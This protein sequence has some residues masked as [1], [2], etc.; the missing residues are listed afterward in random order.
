M[1][2]ITCTARR[3]A[4]TF[5][6][7]LASLSGAIAPAPWSPTA[8]AADT[9]FVA[10]AED[11][12]SLRAEPAYGAEILATLA[13]G[14]QV[15]LRTD[16]ADTVND[17]DG[18]TR[19]WPVRTDAG[20]GWVAGFY[21]E[22]DGW[23][24]PAEASEPSA[25]EAA[26]AAWLD[27]TPAV[28]DGD[29]GWN[30]AGAARAIVNDPSGVNLRAEPG[31]AGLPLEVV[32]QGVAVDLRLGSAETV[33]A[34]GSRWWP[35]SVDGIAGW[36]SGDF[37]SPFDGVAPAA[38]AI[39]AEP[40]WEEPAPS[41]VPNDYVAVSTGD[42]AGLNI[43]ADGAPDAERVGLAPEGDVIQVMDGP[44][45]DP[46]GNP[47]YM[48]TTGSVTGWVFGRYLAKAEGLP[49]PARQTA[50]VPDA[51][52]PAAAKDEEKP[53]NDP[54]GDNF[55]FG[56]NDPFGKGFP[57]GDAGV[58]TGSFMYPVKEFKFTQGFGCSS[59][60]LEPWEASLGCHFHNGID[61]AANEWT[62][63][64]AADGG[65]VMQAGWCDCGLGY[66]VKI[67]HGNGFRTVYGHLVAYAVSPGQAVAKGERIGS[68]GNT[69]N[70]TGSH[71]H[72]ITQVNGVPY[73][74]LWYMP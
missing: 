55:P 73:D 21:L 56:D 24:S 36:I 3:F 47:W 48:V 49:A 42:G 37:L 71:L 46:L 26:I 2:R 38:P 30:L 63:V 68:V 44:V 50:A 54:F 10:H 34:D 59:L 22:L 41:F 19:W 39:D 66:Y 35:V 65:I 52:A 32:S 58:A 5:A 7:A 11:G 28:I 31:L 74:P 6:V 69:G 23:Q 20:T 57:F 67:D 40:V 18:R 64:L 1:V 51:S 60:W 16:E 27:T 12:L 62:P 43:R 33:Y 4:L 17:P 14:T 53:K 25:S 29:L 13:N 15:G 9:A 61:L 70:S 45:T 8:L 72:F